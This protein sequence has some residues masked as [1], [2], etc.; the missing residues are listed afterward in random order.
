MR[1]PFRKTASWNDKIPIKRRHNLTPGWQMAFWK[2]FFLF[3]LK[4]K[5]LLQRLVMISLGTFSTK[6]KS[7]SSSF[8][9]NIYIFNIFCHFI[10]FERSILE[11]WKGKNL[12]PLGVKNLWFKLT[13]LDQKYSDRNFLRYIFPL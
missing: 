7:I 6:I 3:G 1:K 5:S 10:I 13:I 11:V 8:M 12:Y 2:P 4:G 9:K